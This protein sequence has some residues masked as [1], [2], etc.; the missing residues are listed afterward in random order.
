VFESSYFFRNFNKLCPNEELVKVTLDAWLI[1]IS[2][3]YSSASKK[4]IGEY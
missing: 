2:E 3:S 1:N 4:G